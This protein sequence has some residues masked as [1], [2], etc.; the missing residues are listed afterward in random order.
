M[1]WVTILRQRD[2]KE[3][4]ASTEMV[5]EWNWMNWNVPGHSGVIPIFK[6]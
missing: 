4:T 3:F 1:L 5:T 2:E 6:T